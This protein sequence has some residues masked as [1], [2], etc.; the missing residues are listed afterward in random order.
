MN[1]IRERTPNNPEAPKAMKP[2]PGLQG[3]PIPRRRDSIKMAVE[4][5]S[6][7]RL[8]QRSYLTIRT[9][10]LLKALFLPCLAL[11]GKRGEARQA[12]QGYKSASRIYLKESN[13]F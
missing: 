10:A 5:T 13:V 11:Q 3:D 9:P 4:S 8:D 2:V 1:R 12:K 7:K 6:Q